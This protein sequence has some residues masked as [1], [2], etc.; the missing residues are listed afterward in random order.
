[1]KTYSV[2]IPKF[3]GGQVKASSTTASKGRTIT[4]TVTPDE[5]YKL[6][7]LTVKDA[8]GTE[9]ILTDKGEGK[10]SFTM[11]DSKVTVDAVFVEIT[12]PITPDSPAD[13]TK[14]ENPAL[15]FTDVTPGAYYYDAVLWVVEKG[16]TTGTTATTFSPEAT[17]TRAQTVT[18]LWRAAGSPSP[19][20]TN[21]PFT[22][23]TPGEYYYD[24]VLWAVEQGITAGTSATTFSPDATVTRGETVTFLHRANG[25]PIADSNCSFTDID[26]SAYYYNAVLWAV[27]KN[28]TTGTSNTTFGPDE[29]CTR[30]Q[31]VTFLY[32]ANS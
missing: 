29:S 27:E 6:D 17:C 18:F 26:S 20:S 25:M 8:K 10:Y 1:V 21:N 16:V 12:A 7:T 31:I 14:P 23:V 3:T 22:D 32:R 30:G 19:S 4:L 28:V 11:P 15:H 24:A 5:G 13:T 2:T 9:L